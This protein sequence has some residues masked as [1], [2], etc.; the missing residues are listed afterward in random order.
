M[1]SHS[2]IL[3]TS[4]TKGTEMNTDEAVATI[5]DHLVYMPGWHF[6]VEPFEKRFQNTIR[7]SVRYPAR[8][9]NK[10]DAPAGYPNDVP[11]GAKASFT[12]PLDAIHNRTELTIALQ[13]TVFR[14]IWEHESREFLRWD[15]LEFD[16]PIHPHTRHGMANWGHEAS[17]YT[18]GLA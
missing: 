7:I 8:N 9:S 11:G 6:E 1:R 4:A 14:S 12:L 5:T 15:D 13:K 10:E 18:F 3:P 17:D 16:A 2:V